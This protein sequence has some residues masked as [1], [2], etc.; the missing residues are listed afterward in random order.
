[1]TEVS[2]RI[3]NHSGGGT[4]GQITLIIPSG[5]AERVKQGQPSPSIPGDMV[6]VVGDTLVVKNEDAVDHQLGPF[7]IPK[8][9]SAAVTFNQVAN[10]AYTCTFSPEKYLGLEVKAPLTVYTRA[11]GILDAGIP[12][13]ILI[14]LYVVFAIRPELAKEAGNK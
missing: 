5:T 13:G 9:T 12:L 6:F 4:P 14:A 8:G 3:Q 10:L 1:M 2:Y 7:F 11:I